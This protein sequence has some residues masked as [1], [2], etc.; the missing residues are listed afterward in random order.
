MTDQT[1]GG[2]VPK[3]DAGS[4]IPDA[5]VNRR[6]EAA[7][8]LALKFARKMVHAAHVEDVTHETLLR[9]VKGW[10]NT[11]RGLDPP[12]A[13]AAVVYS[14]VTQV[15]AS[16][17][18]SGSAADERDA[19][20]GSA[21]ASEPPVWMDPERSLEAADLDR[22]VTRAYTAVEKGKRDVHIMVREDGMSIVEVAQVLDVNE[23]T[24]RRW[25]HEVESV[26]LEQLKKHLSPGFGLRSRGNTTNG[27]ARIQWRRPEATGDI[28]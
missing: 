28:Q 16:F 1:N 26:L 13:L 25:L 4:A 11:P 17:N 22:E 2:E 14:E 10:H 9:L 5:E 18:R 15:A 12:R 6:C 20:F 23:K 27:P 7:R 24:V 21:L 8:P 3:G 19:Q